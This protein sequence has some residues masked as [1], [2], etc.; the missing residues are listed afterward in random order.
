MGGINMKQWIKEAIENAS[1]LIEKPINIILVIFSFVGLLAGVIKY[2][3]IPWYAMESQVY[4]KI[5]SKYFKQID[6]GSIYNSLLMACIILLIIACLTIFGHKMGKKTNSSLKLI[7]YLIH[8]FL[9]IMVMIL[10]YSNLMNI[11][12]KLLSRHYLIKFVTAHISSL[13]WWFIV[14]SFIV[15]VILIITTFFHKMKILK[16]ILILFTIGIELASVYLSLPTT[17][18]EKSQYEVTYISDEEGNG[19]NR[20]ILSEI[21]GK[22]F[23]VP[24]GF[25]DASLSVIF[26]TGSYKLLPMEELEVWVT[27]FNSG[28]KIENNK[29]ID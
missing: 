29:T 17:P 25:E 12:L 6:M 28:I 2:M 8:I 19:E 14:F 5:P 10:N 21:D 18:Q 7:S 13:P 22:Y 26:Y 9:G 3:Y 27:R 20:V 15:G 4:Y 23:T 16:L 11:L 1:D 24:Y